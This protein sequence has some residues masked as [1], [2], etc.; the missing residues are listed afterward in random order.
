MIEIN[1][2]G[3]NRKASQSVEKI[4]FTIN[5]IDYLISSEFGELKIQAHHHKLV[6]KPCFANVITVIGVE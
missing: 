2:I 6:V 1:R 4:G 3:S 5:G